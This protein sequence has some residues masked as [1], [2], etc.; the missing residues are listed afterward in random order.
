MV[1]QT[2]RLGLPLLAAGQAQKEISHNA[3]LAMLDVLVQPVVHRFG[4][5][6]P[7]VAPVIGQSWIVGSAPTGDWTGQPHAIATWRGEGWEY[8][9]PA[10][11]SRF[12]V[13]ADGLWA[14][15]GEGGWTRGILPCVSLKIGGDQ[16]V[17][18]RQPAIAAPTGGSTVDTEARTALAAV[19]VALKTH[20]LIAV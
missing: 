12:W 3:A 4:D 1:D 8:L 5:N 17:G 13:V 10:E 11:G 16:V 14:G 2:A 15:F 6:D 7:P 19:I 9:M 20:G 18:A